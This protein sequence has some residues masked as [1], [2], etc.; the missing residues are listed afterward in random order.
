MTILKIFQNSG[1]DWFLKLLVW[2]EKHIKEKNF[3]LILAL[4]IGVLSGFAALFLKFLIG[5]IA[6]MVTSHISVS[7][8]NYLY[9]IFPVLG[10]LIS[11][12][13]V[14]YVVRD[15]ISHGVTKV[16]YALSQKKS[17]LKSHNMYTSVLASSV[18]IGFG[19]SVGAE[20]PIV[21]TG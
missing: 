9:L 6:S 16:L 14:R 21:Y 13:F 10:I 19:G 7:E 20:G 8:G 3:V 12:I 5:L 2:R 15:N 17:R 11:G 1:R 18:T 4:I